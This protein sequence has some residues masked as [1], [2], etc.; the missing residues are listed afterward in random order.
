[1]DHTDLRVNPHAKMLMMFAKSLPTHQTEVSIQHVQEDDSKLLEPN[2]LE[3]LY[4]MIEFHSRR[5]RH[6]MEAILVHVSSLPMTPQDKM[7]FRFMAKHLSAKSP[8]AGSTYLPSTLA[9]PTS[10]WTTAGMVVAAAICGL[11]FG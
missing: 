6:T 1:V 11:I 3:L 4:T 8:R 2:I 5:T 9:M 7:I 10:S